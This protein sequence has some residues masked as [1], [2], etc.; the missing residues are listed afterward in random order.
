MTTKSSACHCSMYPKW[1]GTP[2]LM[3]DC[4][5]DVSFQKE[6]NVSVFNLDSFKNANF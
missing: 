3:V 6:E 1:A 2:L 5:S 4:G